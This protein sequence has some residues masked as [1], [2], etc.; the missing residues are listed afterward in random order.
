MGVASGAWQILPYIKKIKYT[1]C[2]EMPEF[3]CGLENK[4]LR[5]WKYEVV[6]FK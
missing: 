6:I 4:V 1:R 3:D 5:A 2:E